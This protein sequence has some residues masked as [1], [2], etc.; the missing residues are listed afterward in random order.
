VRQT[1]ENALDPLAEQP[2][3]VERLH[4]Q[5]DAARE[6]RMRFRDRR[7][8]VIARRDGDDLGVRM[9]QQNLDQLAGGV[10]SAAENGDLCH[11]SVVRGCRNYHTRRLAFT[12]HL[13]SRFD[14]AP[15][16]TH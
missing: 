9:P 16:I 14:H 7:H 2:V 3:G 5:V 6:A 4:A 10:T 13:L 15:R 8:L 11:W 12:V 1:T